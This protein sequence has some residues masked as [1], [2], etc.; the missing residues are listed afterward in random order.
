MEDGQKLIKS[1]KAYF[2]FTRHSTA[3]KT[4]TSLA[5][6]RL[7]NTQ[8]YSTAGMSFAGVFVGW[9]TV[10]IDIVTSWRARIND[11]LRLTLGL[12][13]PSLSL[14]DLRQATWLRGLT[15]RFLTA[16]FVM[17]CSCWSNARVQ[18]SLLLVENDTCMSVSFDY[19][20]SGESNGVA[21]IR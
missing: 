1:Q 7:A 5:S 14:T 12:S 21:T 10:D 17:L 8:H 6:L 20:M 15:K 19:A 9:S 11:V 13:G 18:T 2:A 16:A 3:S 4:L